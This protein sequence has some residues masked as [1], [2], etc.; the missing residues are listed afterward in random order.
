MFH[1]T[2]TAGLREDTR[3]IEQAGIEKTRARM[4]QA[5]ILLL[6][7]DL[8]TYQPQKFENWT[9]EHKRKGQKLLLVGNKADL[10][11]TSARETF[12]EQFKTSHILSAK[13]STGLERLK[14]SLYKETI[15]DGYKDST[16]ISHVRHYELLKEAHDMLQELIQDLKQEQSADLLAVLLRAILRKIGEITGEVYTEDILAHIFSNFCIGK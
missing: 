13:H 14:K 3:T 16:L 7:V 2:D 10:L 4:K 6:V 15:D 5:S 9:S 8:S 1:L 11:S 12:S